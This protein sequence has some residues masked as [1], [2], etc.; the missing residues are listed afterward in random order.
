MPDDDE[1]LTQLE[2]GGTPPAPPAPAPRTVV[3]HGGAAI[4]EEHVS[5]IRREAAARERKRL[6]KDEYGTDDEEEVKK[7]RVQRQEQI[8]KA[9]KLEEDREKARLAELSENE[10]LKSELATERQQ[11]AEEKARLERE[12]DSHKGQLELE[13]QDQLVTG[14]AVKHVAP[15]FLKTAKVEFGEY[16]D[17]LN[18]TELAAVDQKATEKWFADYVKKNPE[19]APPKA[20]PAKTA[21][22]LAAAAPSPGGRVTNGRWSSGSAARAAPRQWA[23]YVQG[24]AGRQAEQDRTARVLREQ[25]NEIAVLR[26]RVLNM[27]TP[28]PA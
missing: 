19:F 3:G 13:R 27:R 5:Q 8:D 18:K 9:K 10:R 16:L 1:D 23:R 7:I 14:L 17:T 20:T 4:P 2:P 24:Q 26:T 6:W 21:E 15:K 11:R 22:E 12:R 25:R 28:P